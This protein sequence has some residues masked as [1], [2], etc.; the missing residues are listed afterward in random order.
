MAV[1]GGKE[2]GAYQVDSGVSISGQFIGLLAFGKMAL[3]LGLK[4]TY[5]LVDTQHGVTHLRRNVSLYVYGTDALTG[6]RMESALYFPPLA[7]GFDVCPRGYTLQL[8]SAANGDQTGFCSRCENRQYSVSPLAGPTAGVPSCFNCPPSG[9]CAGGDDVTFSRGT[10]EIR[11]GMYMLVG[12]PRG[13]QLVNS[14]GGVFS[15]DVQDCVQCGSTQYI[16]DSNNSAFECQNCPLGAI[17]DGSTFTS[18]VAG[19]VWTVD[20]SGRYMLKNC[21]PG[22]QRLASTVDA[23]QCDQCAALHYCEGGTAAAVACKDGTYAPPG[24]NSSSACQSSVMVEV[25]VGLPL[26]KDQFGADQ[27]SSFVD[28]LAAAARVSSDRVYISQVLGHTD[29]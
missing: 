7:T 22:Y 23:Q 14:I 26:S 18:R 27:E 6:D 4:P 10:W 20:S 11:Q 19:A 29:R 3:T 16:V 15:H 21:P 5:Q 13:Y 1:T 17:C 24:S 25:V 12:C 8:E 28:A 2:S 9:D